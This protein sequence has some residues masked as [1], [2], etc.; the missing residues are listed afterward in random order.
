MKMACGVHENYLL[1]PPKPGNV[2]CTLMRLN[3]HCLRPAFLHKLK[4]IYPPHWLKCKRAYFTQRVLPIK[5]DHKI[6]STYY[7]FC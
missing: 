2:K 6:S 4:I 7:I 3:K 5:K 1:N